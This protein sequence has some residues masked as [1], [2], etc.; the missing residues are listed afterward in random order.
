MCRCR[1]MYLFLFTSI[2][3]GAMEVL[4]LWRAKTE[5]GPRGS[6]E[7]EPSLWYRTSRSPRL[8]VGGVAAHALGSDEAETSSSE[9]EPTPWG[10]TRRKPRPWSRTRR[11]PAPEGQKRPQLLP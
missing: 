2:D 10:R 6:D 5:S 3:D 8:G 4:P 9:S 1:I 11:G 7:A